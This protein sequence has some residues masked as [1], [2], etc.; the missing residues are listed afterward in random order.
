MS[1]DK[2]RV[3]SLLSLAKYRVVRVDEESGSRAAALQIATTHVLLLAEIRIASRAGGRIAA[4]ADAPGGDGQR[5]GCHGNERDE[6]GVDA[7]FGTAEEARGG[8]KGGEAERNDPAQ[9]E[10]DVAGVDGERIA[11]ERQEIPEG[12][13]DADAVLEPER[14]R[15]EKEEDGDVDEAA[16]E[17]EE[18]EEKNIERVPLIVKTV[19]SPDNDNQTDDDLL[20]RL[21][22]ESIEDHLE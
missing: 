13:M 7:K 1:R 16:A 22:A 11:A 10:L 17:R 12:R 21:D 19:R 2:R 20:Q 14:K 6:R 5:E 18:D 9:Q 8:I 3:H 15:G 4:E